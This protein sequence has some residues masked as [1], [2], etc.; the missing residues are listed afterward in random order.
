MAVK[1]YADDAAAELQGQS[2]MQCRANNGA[3][4]SDCADFCADKGYE[5]KG[6][7]KGDGMAEW[8]TIEHWGAKTTSGQ[9]S[10]SCETDSETGSCACGQNSLLQTAEYTQE[11][12][13]Q[14]IEEVS[15]ENTEDEDGSAF[16]TPRCVTKSNCKLGQDMQ[17]WSRSNKMWCPG[18]IVGVDGYREQQS[19]LNKKT[20]SCSSKAK[21]GITVNYTCKVK[22]KSTNLKKMVLWNDP[23]GDNVN[24]MVQYNSMFR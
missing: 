5:M 19:V 22:G 6:C 23:K 3:G 16:C 4:S 24:K 9:S 15:V 10:W 21:K 7:M 20:V 18:K 1:T 17:I 2:Y 12:F 13:E 11:V 8:R 14:S